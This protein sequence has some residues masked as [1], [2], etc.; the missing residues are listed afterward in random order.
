MV[1]LTRRPSG[2]GD[3]DQLP[4]ELGRGDVP[5]HLGRGGSAHSSRSPSSREPRRPGRGSR[6]PAGRC[7]RRT[8]CRAGPDRRAPTPGASSAAWERPRPP[9]GATR[10]RRRVAQP[11]PVAGQRGELG[12]DRVFAAVEQGARASRP[13][14]AP[15]AVRPASCRQVALVASHE[16]QIELQ[17]ILGV[18]LQQERVGLAASRRSGRWGRTPGPAGPPPARRRT[19]GRRARSRWR[20]GARRWRAGRARGRA[21]PAAAPPPSVPCAPA[22]APRTGTP[23]PIPASA[24]GPPAGVRSTSSCGAR[25]MSSASDRA[26][27][28]SARPG[29]SS[30]ARSA[31]AS[32]R[33]TAT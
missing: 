22:R 4:Q 26:R 1:C 19:A 5:L 15:S 21:A 7:R 20:S 29:S 32:A 27:W 12:H 33:A 6:S 30:T 3:V 28:A 25:L 17:A 11:G 8:R 31:S 2:G 9:S 24:A 18:A 10:R 14:P 13:A 23:P 16:R